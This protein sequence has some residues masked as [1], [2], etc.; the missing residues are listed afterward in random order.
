MVPDHKHSFKRLVEGRQTVGSAVLVAL[1]LGFQ[2][3]EVLIAKSTAD[4]QLS[5]DAERVDSFVRAIRP[6]A[7]VCVE[8]F[9]ATV[10]VHDAR[11]DSDLWHVSNASIALTHVPVSSARAPAPVNEYQCKKCSERAGPT[12]FIRDR[13]SKQS[14]LL[15]FQAGSSSELM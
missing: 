12:P 4:P 1:F 5:D 9:F 6:I 11:L 13:L 14:Q 7:Q 8:N 2:S 3:C 15:Q 10:L